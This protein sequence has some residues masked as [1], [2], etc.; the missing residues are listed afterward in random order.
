VRDG[1]DVACSSVDLKG[2]FWF[3]LE[4][5]KESISLNKITALKRWC[6]WQNRFEFYK[7]KYDLRCIEVKYEDLVKE[8]SK[9]LEKILK[10]INVRWSI[11][12]L[13]YSDKEHDLPSW[14]AGSNDV[15]NNSKINRKSIGRWKNEFT[16]SEKIEAKEIADDILTKLGYERT[17]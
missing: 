4:N 17:V 7:Q 9:N 1:R 15:K 11:D 16:G 8:P 6:E 2:K 3:S 13:N 12:V 10:F 14:E 5:S